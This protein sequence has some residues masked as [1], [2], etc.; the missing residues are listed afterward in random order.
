MRVYRESQKERHRNFE[1]SI[2]MI[3]NSKSMDVMP[4]KFQ[5]LRR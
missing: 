3:Q 2:E 4:T 5:T 1:T